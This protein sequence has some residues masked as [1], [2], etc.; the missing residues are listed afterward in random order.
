VCLVGSIYEDIVKSIESLD[1]P[2]VLFLD[3]E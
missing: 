3:I 2:D 1:Y